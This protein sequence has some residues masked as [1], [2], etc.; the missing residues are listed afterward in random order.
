M[1]YGHDEHM[2]TGMGGSEKSCPATGHDMQD[3]Y[4][5]TRRIRE[6]YKQKSKDCQITDDLSPE[7]ELC[8]DLTE[9]RDRMKRRKAAARIQEPQGTDYE[10]QPDIIDLFDEMPSKAETDS[11]ETP[12]CCDN[13]P[14]LKRPPD[15]NECGTFIDSKLSPYEIAQRLIKLIPFLI[16]GGALY[17]FNGIVFEIL[18]DNSLDRLIVKCFRR[19]IEMH[20]K[21]DIIKA[22]RTF[23]KSE[24]ELVIDDPTIDPNYIVM[25][26]GRINLYTM[27]FEPNDATIFQTSYLNIDF[28]PKA[29]SCPCFDKY[30]NTVADGDQERMELMLQVH[31]YI[32]SCSMD[33]KK[34]FI[35]IGE[36]DTGKSLTIA[37]DTLLFPNDYVSTIE[38]QSLGDKFST[39]NLA[40]K[41]LN[42]GG[43]LPNK[44]LT[45]DAIKHVKGITGN[46]M[47]TAEQKFVQPFA[48]KPSCKLVFATNHPL[49]LQQRDDQF[50]ERLVIIPFDHKIP[51]EEQDHDLLNKLK[52]ELPAIFNKLLAA[53]LRLRKNNYIFPDLS[54]VSNYISTPVSEGKA[55]SHLEEAIHAFVAQK[56]EITGQPEDFIPISKLCAEF[57]SFYLVVYNQSV[58]TD[59]F[60]KAFRKLY[61]KTNSC[62]Y[63]QKVQKSKGRGYIGI[64]FKQ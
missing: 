52:A 51:K 29:K 60:S 36:G 10:N 42:I 17:F 63:P 7:L 49:I 28:D 14:P 57:N 18:D 64:A 39:G 47:M 56:C 40:G 25:R 44:P 32:A 50:C 23:V 9:K 16:V 55:E 62:E 21:P 54:T 59:K 43:D 20:G 31:G 37:F 45:P 3:G 11:Q 33:A 5:D 19:I 58:D 26:N 38:L 6:R 30:L 61:D 53:Y 1:L 27:K 34:L 8:S 24:P 2:T 41:R 12:L 4:G 13:A 35:Y 15:N 22:V 46:D 48:Y